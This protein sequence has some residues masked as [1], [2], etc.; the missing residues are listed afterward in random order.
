MYENKEPLKKQ[1]KFANGNNTGAKTLLIIDDEEAVLK[2]NTKILRQLGYAVYATSSG[3][4][5]VEIYKKQQVEIAAVLSDLQMPEMNGLDVHKELVKINPSVKFIILSSSFI[6]GDVVKALGIKAF[7]S[8][9]YTIDE[10]GNT[11]R[12]VL[13]S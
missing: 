5:A 10:I 6:N 12:R 1:N 8:K 9:P 7:I 3:P 4:A 11:I 13:D 2:V